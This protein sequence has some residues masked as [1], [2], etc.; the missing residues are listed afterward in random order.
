MRQAGGEAFGMLG[1]GRGEHGRSRRDAL[2]GHAMVHV[3]GRQQAEA[4]MMVIGV[5]PLACDSP[6]GTS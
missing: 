1:V 3:G 5:V 2:F 6:F 4:R